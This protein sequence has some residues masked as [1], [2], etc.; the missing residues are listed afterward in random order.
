[1]NGY[2]VV[3]SES[4]HPN[5]HTHTHAVP[6]LD[7]GRYGVALLASLSDAGREPTWRSNSEITFQPMAPPDRHTRMPDNSNILRGCVRV[8]NY[9]AEQASNA[10]SS[11]TLQGCF[12]KM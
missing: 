8:F 3:T 4:I 12:P 6:A 5:T 2:L 9:T 10:Q 11:P 1:M 7:R